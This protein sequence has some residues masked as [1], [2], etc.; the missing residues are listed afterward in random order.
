MMTFT[1]Y[2]RLAF[3]EVLQSLDLKSPIKL[4]I[5]IITLTFRCDMQFGPSRQTGQ[6]ANH[7]ST[8]NKQ[9]T[10]S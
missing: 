2:A 5:Q 10:C 9:N 7:F 3:S 6:S 4:T 8:E 1:K